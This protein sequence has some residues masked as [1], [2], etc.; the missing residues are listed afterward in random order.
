M[1]TIHY[2]LGKKKRGKYDIFIF[3]C[4]CIKKQLKGDVMDK[5]MDSSA[6]PSGF[7]T[8]LHHTA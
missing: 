6:G 8:L 3:A 5:A 1:K 7:K 2:L 4:I